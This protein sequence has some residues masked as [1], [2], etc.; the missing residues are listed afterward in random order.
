[1]IKCLK[2]EDFVINEMFRSY[3]PSLKELCHEYG[4]K[5]GGRASAQKRVEENL[6]R[7][8]ELII[9]LLNEVP[10]TKERVFNRLAKFGG[11]KFYR[12]LDMD[13]P[14]IRYVKDN[15]SEVQT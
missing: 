4:V 5:Y 13:N 3:M 10:E 7:N 1:M 6:R 11:V 12:Y 9:V 2:I 14:V 8:P 15:L